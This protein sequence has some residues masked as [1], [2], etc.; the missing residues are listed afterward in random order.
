[1]LVGCQLQERSFQAYLMLALEA[2]YNVESESVGS[3][4]GV[5]TG[6]KRG[7]GDHAHVGVVEA[8]VG[9]ERVKAAD[10]CTIDQTGRDV[11]ELSGCQYVSLEPDRSIILTLTRWSTPWFW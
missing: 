3:G 7:G 1:M 4:L 8:L 10:G 9:A 6:E 11:V 2:G 5:E